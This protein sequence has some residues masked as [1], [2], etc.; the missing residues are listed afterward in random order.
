[1]NTVVLKHVGLVA[2]YQEHHKQIEN[3]KDKG[4][5]AKNIS[6]FVQLLRA[7]GEVMHITMPNHPSSTWMNPFRH[8]KQKRKEKNNYKF[9]PL[10]FII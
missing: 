1:M 3:I 6:R 2:E 5:K 7:L 8:M 4:K 10:K 9:N